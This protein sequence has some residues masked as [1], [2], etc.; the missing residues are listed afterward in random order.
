M[1]SPGFANMVFNSFSATKEQ[2]RCGDSRRVILE[3]CLGEGLECPEKPV[4]ESR[5]ASSFR[6]RLLG[7]VESVIEVVHNSVM[8]RAFTNFRHSS[9][10][11][12][13]D[14]AAACMSSNC[15]VSVLSKILDVM[16]GIE[17]LCSS[18]RVQNHLV[19]RLR[20]LFSLCFLHEL[21][22]RVSATSAFIIGF[23]WKVLD[24]VGLVG[25]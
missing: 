10:S 18:L 20:L 13:M 4:L 9:H 21:P 16:P 2:E 1:V 12:S 8:F 22:V 11:L 3:P 17:S 5:S 24:K 25:A 15:L 14:F 19:F 6:G 23:V 7:L